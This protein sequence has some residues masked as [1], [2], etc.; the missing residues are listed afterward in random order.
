MS[1]KTTKGK[2][3]MV[4]MGTTEWIKPGTS[5]RTF[6]REYLDR[7]W[8]EHRIGL[9]SSAQKRDVKSGCKQFK[10]MVIEALKKTKI[11]GL[12]LVNTALNLTDYTPACDKIID[13]YAEKITDG[14]DIRKMLKKKGY[15][16]VMTGVREMFGKDRT[17]HEVKERVDVIYCLMISEKLLEEIFHDSICGKPV[18]PAPSNAPALD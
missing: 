16:C 12:V 1:A 5:I 9:F 18:E 6:F 17:T 11:E 15:V 4:S 2:T 7:R 13:D 10:A 8:E 3:A 14:D